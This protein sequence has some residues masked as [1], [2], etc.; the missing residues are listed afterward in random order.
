MSK[1]TVIGMERYLNY[2]N[3]SLFADATFPEGI[4]KD[5]VVNTCLLR[6][7]EFEVLYSD[8]NFMKEQVTFWSR[9]YALTFQKWLEGFE[10]EF[11]PIEN[12]DR[13][14]HWTDEHGGSFTHGKTESVLNGLTTTNEVSAYDSS[15]FQPE[16]KTTNSGTDKTTFSGTDQDEYENEHTGRVHGNI[17]VTTAPKM[18]EE[19]T[20]FYKTHNLY[21]LIADIF[22]T[23]FCI[24]VY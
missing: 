2:S 11:N 18:L 22:V 4:D 5:Q 21:D 10:A 6:S 7:G 17:G 15:S 1:I 9:R 8:A 12:Y 19:Y 13:Q 3:D 14:E 23:E 20:A 24:M 16:S